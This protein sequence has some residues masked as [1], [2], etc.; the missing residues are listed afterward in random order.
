MSLVVDNVVKRFQLGKK[1]LFRFFSKRQRFVTALEGVS[2]SI[3]KGETVVILGESGSGK[4]TLGR[5]IVGL[6]KPDQGKIL[7]NGAK[8]VYVR[9]R[10]AL[11]GRLQM[12]FQDPGASLDPFQSVADC[13]AEPILQSGHKKEEITKKVIESLRLVGLEESSA[14]RKTSELSGGQKQRV[15]IARA[16][17]SE[18]DVIVLDEPTSSI[19][20]SI[21]AQVLNLLV[22]LQRLKGYT[23]V[24]ITHDPNVA[25]FMADAVAVMYLG[26][27]VEYGPLSRVLDNP[28]H[29]YT[30]ALLLSAPK[31]TGATSSKPIQGEPPSLINIPQGCR[32]EPRCPYSMAKCKEKEPTP[33]QIDE[34]RVSCFLYEQTQL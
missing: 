7:L 28:K 4:T 10:G 29:P 23:Y 13:V 12:V 15:A 17:V 19:D 34:A 9:E 25:R 3:K 30:Q 1:S 8:V 20:V 2:L 33:I 24:L 14:K 31:I 27:I 26:K 22:E 32:Y 11:R 21:Q 18:P 5:I 16:I 6:E